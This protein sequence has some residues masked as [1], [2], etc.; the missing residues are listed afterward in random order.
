MSRATNAQGSYSN[1]LRGRVVFGMLS[2]PGVIVRFD[3]RFLSFASLRILASLREIQL[4]RVS[5]KATMR[6]KR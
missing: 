2:S 3:K 5:R 1:A 4:Q 6:L